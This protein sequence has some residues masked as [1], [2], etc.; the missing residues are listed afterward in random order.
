MAKILVVDDSG[1]A[2]RTLNKILVEAGHEV[3]LVNDGMAALEQ[4][5]LIPYDLVMLDLT[6]PGMPGLDVLD[7]LI[8][9]DPEARVLIATADIQKTSREL[10]M[11]GGAIGFLPKPFKTEKVIEAVNKALAGGNNADE[12][13]ANG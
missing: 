3:T 6:M 9:L 5:T 2:R 8:S 11:A 10:S 13:K 4:F 7:K 1:L 12:S